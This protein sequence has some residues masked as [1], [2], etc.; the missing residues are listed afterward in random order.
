MIDL[1]LKDQL[2]S[3]IIE[4]ETEKFISTSEAYDD[5][6][7]SGAMFGLV[8]DVADTTLAELRHDLFYYDANSERNDD[9]TQLN[10][11]IQSSAKQIKK[12]KAL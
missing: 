11:A 5:N 4:S 12:S 6:T 8:V 7:K 3:H 10:E 1:Y 2:T 9:L